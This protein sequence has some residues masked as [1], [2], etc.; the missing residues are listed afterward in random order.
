[1]PLRD[2]APTYDVPWVTL[3]LIVANVAVFLWQLSY[4]GGI[5]ASLQVWGEV[6]ARI[7]AGGLVP[8]TA[9]PAGWT[10]I[11]AMFMHANVGHLLGNLYALW[12]FGDNVE[13]VMGRLRFVVFYLICGGCSSL[14]T[15]LLG[16]GSS[17]PGIGASGAIAGVL[18]GYLIMYPRARVTTLMWIDP[19]DCTD[20]DTG[21]VGLVV[22]NISALWFVGSWLIFEV[23]MTAIALSGQVWMNLGIYAH[24][25]GALAGAAFVQLLAIGERVPKPD[26]PERSAPLTDPLF[27]QEGAAG[28]GTQP[29]ATL[30]EEV[31]RLHELRVYRG[32]PR[33]EP[34]RDSRAEELCRSGQWH[35]AL[36]HCR[37]MLAVAREEGNDWQVDGYLAKI[38]E[39]LGS[40]PSVE[41]EQTPSQLLDI[42]GGNRGGE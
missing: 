37:E 22:R 15:V 39:I 10:V 40:V 29:V 14:A 24:V 41:E 8:G 23:A 1:M 16:G 30:P 12:L 19:E 3:A 13:W 32:L 18:A 2:N 20:M 35:R 36:Q 9:V 31:E 5:A 17:L 21:D 25:A 38:S 42:L 27:G 34:F 7:L 4:P 6:P 28:G 11:T 26:S 33:P